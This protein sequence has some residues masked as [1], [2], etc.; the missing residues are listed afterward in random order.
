[1]CPK[2]FNISIIPFQDAQG[3]HLT[4][5]DL[6]RTSHT[7]RNELDSEIIP[8]LRGRFGVWGIGLR[9]N[10]GHIVDFPRF[11]LEGDSTSEALYLAI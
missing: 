3:T 8:L 4:N 7:S 2:A 5:Q 1:V 10:V 11:D 6:G 9:R